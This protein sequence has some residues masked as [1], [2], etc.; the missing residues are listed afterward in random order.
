[1]RRPSIPR[2]T[3]QC[4]R[5]E[6]GVEIVSRDDV[7]AVDPGHPAACAAKVSRLTDDNSA[8]A[9]AYE[10]VV[11]SGGTRVRLP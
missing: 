8:S 6:H 4:G 10:G 5:A 1:M 2:A 11:R 3:A 7:L 9:A